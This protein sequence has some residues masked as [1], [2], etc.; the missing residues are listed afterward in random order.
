MARS[1]LD[2]PTEVPTPARPPFDGAL[3]SFQVR[4]EVT[5]RTT[6]NHR[7]L[8]DGSNWLWAYRGDDGSVAGITRYGLNAPGKVLR[9][10]A[11]AFDVEI[12]SD[13]EPQ[14]WGFDTQEKWDA[15]MEKLAAEDRDLPGDFRAS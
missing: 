10:I 6:P 15:W 4:E 3:A 8:T 2:E 5:D 11:D 1:H 7:C 14:Y 13:D 12:V 9:A